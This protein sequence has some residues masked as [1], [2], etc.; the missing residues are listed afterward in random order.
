MSPPPEIGSY[1]WAGLIVLLVAAGVS[2]AACGKKG[3][4]LAP[5]H[6]VPAAPTSLSARLTGAEL[7][8]QLV[9][10]L[11]TDSAGGR[12]E[13][14]RLEI[15][16]VTIAP[17]AQAPPN[18]D[19]LTPARLV[20][21]IP[22]RPIPVEGEEAPASAAPDTRPLPGEATT[23]TE[24]LTED[25]MKPVAFAARTPP[26][27][28]TAPAPALTPAI[29]V[30]TYPIRIYAVRG[31]SK[32]G[33]AGQP[34]SRVEV[35]L[36]SP[37]PAP[38]TVTV[39]ATEQ[40]LVFSW[41]APPGVPDGPAITFNVYNAGAG[42]PLNPEPLSVPAFERAG[43]TFGV[44][45]CSTVRSVITVAGVPIESDP[46]APACVTP[47]DAFPPAAPKGLTTVSSPGAISLLWDA[48]TEPDL[49]G[50][51]VL[52][53]EA[54]GGTLQPLTQT[55]TGTRF[56]DKTVTPGVRYIYAVVAV[57]KATPPNTSGQS[58]RQEETAR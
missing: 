12:I 57:D 36:V 32:G 9:L 15:Y 46:S 6:L 30:P 24:Q 14:D 34:S 43:V 23:F 50:Y 4:P 7:K 28:L 31:V 2:S 8:L 16:A 38:T 56:E 52:R 53:G 29:P 44:E 1:G 37:P 48:N 22:V 27:P 18:R 13:L 47:K 21:T 11:G 3:P 19:L 51:V 10:P 33:R 58:P 54:P 5:L 41:T 25:K 42:A 20:G 45:A 55:I 39:S 49:A 35:P 17:G 26:A 40:A